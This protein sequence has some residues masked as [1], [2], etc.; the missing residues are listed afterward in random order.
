M[1]ERIL[2]LTPGS[3]A[4]LIGGTGGLGTAC[5][6]RFQHCGCMVSVTGVDERAM[7][8]FRETPGNDGIDAQVLDVRAAEDIAVYASGVDRVDILVN[9]FGTIGGTAAD[10][11]GLGEYELEEFAR[12][13]DVN[14]TGM[15]RL[16]T[17][18]Q[19]H[20]ARTRGKVI[21]FASMR[22]YFAGPHVPA[23]T[24]SKDG[25]HS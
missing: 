8:Q 10:P 18:F 23:Y 3:H 14:L 17:A 6:R 22:S 5:A 12:V 16:C 19:D 4:V 24:A 25:V 9:A 15:M 11:S 1:P 13:V 20:L 21:N 7:A 2:E